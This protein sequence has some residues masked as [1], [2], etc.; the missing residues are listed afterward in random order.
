VEDAFARYCE[1]IGE[2][3]REHGMFVVGGTLTHRRGR[4]YNTAVM[5]D[6]EGR[7]IASYDKTHL[8]PAEAR[9]IAP[10][11]DLPVFDTPIGKIG[12]LIC[13]DIVFPEPFAVL[14]L[15]GAQIV[16]QPTFGHW[17]ESDDVTARSRAMD[18]SVPVAVSMWGGCA[19]IIDAA[20]NFAARTGRVGDS[21]ALAPL[22]LAASRKWLFFKDTRREKPLMRRT[23][24]YRVLA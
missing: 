6:P 5:Q 14:A 23:E 8:P 11:A 12:L 1:R 24:L 4:Y 2:V 10:G 15:K 20:G 19:C 13:W 7:V 18:W 17:H 9:C 3:C 21:I 16:F 22:D